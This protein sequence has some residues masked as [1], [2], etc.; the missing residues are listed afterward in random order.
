MTDP[1]SVECTV[2]DLTDGEPCHRLAQWEWHP[3]GDL[4]YPV[5]LCNFHAEPLRPGQAWRFRHDME[6]LN[7]QN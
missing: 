2:D 6:I 5:F 7:D 3:D 4:D 1:R